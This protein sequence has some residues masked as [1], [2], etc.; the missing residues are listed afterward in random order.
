[1]HEGMK[2]TQVKVDPALVAAGPRQENIEARLP[3][4][5]VDQFCGGQLWPF[6]ANKVALTLLLQDDVSG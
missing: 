6:E 2:R 5:R 1:M 3:V 4:R